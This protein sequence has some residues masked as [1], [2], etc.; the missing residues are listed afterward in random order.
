M[1][2]EGLVLV[3]QL[4]TIEKSSYLEVYLTKNNSKICLNHIRKY[5]VQITKG[6]L[7]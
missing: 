2:S 7:T 4:E 5:N 1:A 3:L 6:N